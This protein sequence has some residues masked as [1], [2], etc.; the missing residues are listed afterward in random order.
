[1]ISLVTEHPAW[2]DAP[3][4][5]IPNCVDTFSGRALDEALGF[6]AARNGA[7]MS[8]GNGATSM[9]HPDVHNST[10][11]FRCLIAS[12]TCRSRAAAISIRWIAAVGSIRTSTKPFARSH[13]AGYRGI[14]DGPIPT[15]RAS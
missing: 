15:N 6:V 1:M 5:P 11:I 9:S 3:G 13:G 4:K 14:Y 8:N 12:A 10:A 7:E 2:C